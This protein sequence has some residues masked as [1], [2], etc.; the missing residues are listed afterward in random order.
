MRALAEALVMTRHEWSET[1][2]RK[3][4]CLVLMILCELGKTVSDYRLHVEA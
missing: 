3:I 1:V 2:S 4:D